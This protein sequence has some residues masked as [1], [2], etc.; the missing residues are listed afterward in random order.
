M[1]WTKTNY[2]V[3]MKNLPKPVRDKAVE[4]A[5]ALYKNRDMDE[6]LMI[7]T[8][9]SRAKDWA[10]NRNLDVATAR[11][12]SRSSDLKDHGSDQYVIP[13]KDGWAVKSEKSKTGKVFSTKKEAL[14]NA[15]EKA[16]KH[17]AAITVQNKSG[18]IQKRAS[19]NP[20]NKGKK[21]G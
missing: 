1:P 14:E 5:N 18:R 20:N 15:R 11:S 8:A 10:A 2:P 16:K 13:H 17:N 12:S 4:I 3:S 21:T 19:F 6:G 9:I 7:A